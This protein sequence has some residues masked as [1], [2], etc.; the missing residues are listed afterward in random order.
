[1]PQ[2]SLQLLGLGVRLHEADPALGRVLDQALIFVGELLVGLSGRFR[3]R[4]LRAGAFGL[5]SG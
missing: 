3:G 2:V 4:A 5:L 1:M